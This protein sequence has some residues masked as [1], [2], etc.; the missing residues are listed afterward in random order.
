VSAHERERLSAY[1]DDE[2]GAAARAAVEAHLG[3]CASCREALAE[4][5]AVDDAAASLPAEAPEGYFDD[6]AR[7][8]RSRIESQPRAVPAR[9]RLPAWGWAVAA[10]LLLAVVT[11]L[12]LRERVAA[13]ATAPAA[14][15]PAAG[16]GGADRGLL[17][18]STPSRREER[19]APVAKA[20]PR[21]AAPAAAWAPAPA[22][23]PERVA[24]PLAS[25]PPAP[26]QG[27]P[28][29]GTPRQAVAEE[30]AAALG[31]SRAPADA[32]TKGEAANVGGLSDAVSPGR[33]K[34]AGAGSAEAVSPVELEF[35]QLTSEWPVGAE[36]W[37]GLRERWRVFA[38]SHAG[39]AR[40]DE[41]RVRVVACGAELLRAGGD[42]ADRALLE[43]DALA[44]LARADARQKPRVRSLLEASASR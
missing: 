9:R 3:A 16:G 15:V 44:Y 25:E 23:S 33:A 38:T 7:R 37:R 19:A 17:R 28:V 2:L 43:R 29:Q 24:Q 12:T 18:E 36:A 1:L 4:L 14:A 27:M 41:A 11:P 34:A 20:A 6:F 40:A 32:A 42:E 22:A 30:E 35:R 26:V 13:P 21:P 5:A 10:A 39:D 8:V 31:A